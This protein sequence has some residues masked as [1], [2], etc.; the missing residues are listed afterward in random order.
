MSKNL[1]IKDIAKLL[2]LSHGTVDRVI[3]DR[4]GVSDTTRKKVKDFLQEIDFKPNIIARSLKG[5]KAHSVE[6]LIP[7]ETGDSFWE[8]AISGVKAAQKEFNEFTLSVNIRRYNPD[9]THE[10][11]KVA[12][13]A[14]K[15]TPDG[16]LIAPMFYRESLDFFMECKN[17]GIPYAMFNSFVKDAHALYFIGQDLYKSGKVAADLVNRIGSGEGRILIV[18]L[19]EDPSNSSHMLEKERGFRDF[20]TE[21]TKTQYELN[22][23]NVNMHNPKEARTFSELLKSQNNIAGIFVSTSKAYEIIEMAPKASLNEIPFI[24]YDLVDKN[25]SFLKYGVIDFLINQNPFLQAYYGVTFLFEHLLFQKTLPSK[26]LLPID[27]VTD[28][29]Y[30]TYLD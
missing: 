2:N 21:N 1:T 29:N 14:L 15:S 7:G 27:V 23:I 24:G 16:I 26:K 5:S 17:A 18:H 19:D 22:T 30:D 12:D 10:F 4:Y 9:N 8:Q 3:H 25:V 13:D 28:Q 11:K 6:V 20:F